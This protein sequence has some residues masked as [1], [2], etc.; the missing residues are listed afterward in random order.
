MS[1]A[2]MH[3]V[4]HMLRTERRVSVMIAQ[5]MTY[6]DEGLCDDWF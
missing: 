6:G 4:C 2:C 3:N 1:A 5:H